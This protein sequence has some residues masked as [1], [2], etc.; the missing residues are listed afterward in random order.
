MG[1]LIEKNGKFKYIT[2][3]GNCLPQI[4]LTAFDKAVQLVSGS[5]YIE[6]EKLSLRGKITKIR[7]RRQMG[8]NS[9]TECP[10][11]TPPISDVGAWGNQQ[12][13]CEFKFGRGS[14]N[15]YEKAETRQR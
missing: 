11:R 10:L 1:S 8:S 4:S 12:E 15:D 13:L 6:N 7:L 3:Q 9:F 14:L 2:P 5:P